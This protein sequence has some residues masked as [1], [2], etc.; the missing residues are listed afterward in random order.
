M[1]R[2]RLRLNGRLGSSRHLG[3][4]RFGLTALLVATG[5]AAEIA[6]AERRSDFGTMSASTRA[7]Q[8]DDSANP[9]MLAV[10]EGEDL[11]N[12]PA[13]ASGKAC[14]SCHGEAAHSM[15]GAAP[16]YP[17]WS[18]ARAAPIDLAGQIDLCRETRQGAPK[19]PPESR[20]RLALT[21]Y[22]AHQSRGLPIGPPDD[23]RLGPA[24]ERGA[25]TFNARMGQLD[26]SCAQC[27]DQRWGGRL[28]GSTI[29]QAHPVGYPI[30]RLEWQALGSLQRRFRNCLSGVRAEP[31]PYGAPE[32]VDLELFLMA[33]ARGLPLETPAV[34]P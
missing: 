6:P 4:R 17:A 31:Y 32:Y 18:E 26:L 10:Q 24:R 30:Y 3:M 33:R 15:R 29:P 12:A 11:W 9:G 8:S 19:L 5:A 7:M 16:R 2:L 23:P 25:A 20:D 34:R 27:H 22:V 28:G 13:G 14:A 21:A 1:T